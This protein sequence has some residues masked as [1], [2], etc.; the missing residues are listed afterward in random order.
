MQVD[1][2]SRITPKRSAYG[3]ACSRTWLQQRDAVLCE[4]PSSLT[5]RPLA[6][7]VNQILGHPALIQNPDAKLS[8]RKA[9]ALFAPYFEEAMAS[10]ARK[11]LVRTV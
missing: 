5:S 7:L 10:K 8:G 1:N 3:H 6:P 4:S 11:P 2:V 9:N